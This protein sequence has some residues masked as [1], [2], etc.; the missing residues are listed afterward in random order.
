MNGTTGRAVLGRGAARATNCAAQVRQV[1]EGQVLMTCDELYERLEWLVRQL[2]EGYEAVVHANAPEGTVCLEPLSGN[3]AELCISVV[4]DGSFDFAIG[5]DAHFDTYDKDP[6]SQLRYAEHLVK[7][8]LDGGIRETARTGAEGVLAAR[9][10]FP[11]G[12]QLLS[13]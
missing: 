2:A 7:Q 3:G 13:A 8:V 6:H 12:E 10:D 4:N 1:D 9:L 5:P 11:D